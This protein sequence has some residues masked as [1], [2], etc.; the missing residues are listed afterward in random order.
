MEAFKFRHLVWEFTALLDT[1]KHDGI[2]V[3]E[4]KRHAGNGTIPAFLKDRF[5]GEMDTSVLEPEDWIELS[6]EWQSFENTMDEERKMGIKNKGVCLLLGYALESLQ[7][8]ERK[9]E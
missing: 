7:Q 4:V 6:E 5:G 9:K 3:D 2:T 1:G 8:R